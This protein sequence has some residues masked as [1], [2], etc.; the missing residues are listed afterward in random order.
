MSSRV[1]NHSAWPIVSVH[2]DLYCLFETESTTQNLVLFAT[3]QVP[4]LLEGIRVYLISR[5]PIDA[6]AE[7]AIGCYQ[8]TA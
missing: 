5:L 7:L 6:A 1:L 2:A 8:S 4:S 3:C